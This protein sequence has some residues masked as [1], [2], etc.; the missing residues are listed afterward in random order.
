MECTLGISVDH[1]SNVP[2]YLQLVESIIDSIRMEE[3]RKGDRI[4]SINELSETHY[5]SR[6]TVEKAYKVLKERKI[7]IATKG[8][9]YFIN[10]T[11]LIGK[12]NVCFLINKLSSYKMQ[13]Y[14]AM[15]DQL[16][17]GAHVN[18]CI[19][20][21]DSQLFL[22][23]LDRH[24]GAYD[25]YVVMPHF[26]DAHQQHVSSSEEIDNALSRIPPEK[27]IVLDNDK[28]RI[29]NCLARI[30]QDFENDIFEALSSASEKIKKYK[31][32]VLVFP[33]KVIYP[34]PRRILRGFMK[35][36]GIF[37]IDFEVIDAFTSETVLGR[38]SAYIT[39]EENDLVHLIKQAKQQNLK[40]GIDLGVISYND[41]ALKELLEIS[42]I[43]TDFRKMGEYAA[44]AISGNMELCIRNPFNFIDRDS[45]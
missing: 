44:Q 45:L 33:T 4:P 25:Y 7:V 40:C 36:C 30:T 43:T 24:L 28:P 32:V 3:L 27:L 2:K 8:K 26:K 16:G 29:S 42:V 13:I 37:D 17:L 41:T 10:R 18:L 5:L 35:F 12:T 11:S 9:G 20:H 31:K 15:V 19:Y 21:C 1:S 23:L 14:Q 38:H 22:N 34:Y 6:D 39:I